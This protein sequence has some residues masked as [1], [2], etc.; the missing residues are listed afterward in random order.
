V[1]DLRTTP[2]AALAD[3]YQFE[4]LLKNPY[5]LW[6]AWLRIDPTFDQLRSKPG[7]KHLLEGTS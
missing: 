6:S 2:Q 5:Y 3:R 4:P 1:A 7:F